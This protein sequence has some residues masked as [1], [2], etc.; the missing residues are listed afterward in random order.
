MKFGLPMAESIL[1][2]VFQDMLLYSLVCWIFDYT[3]QAH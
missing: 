2:L 3:V 1:R